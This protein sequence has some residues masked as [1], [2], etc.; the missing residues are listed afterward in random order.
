MKFNAALKLIQNSPTA[1]LGLAAMVLGQMV[2]TAVMSMT[3]VHLNH[4]GAS[5]GVIGTI[6][7]G[8]I[9][10]MYIASPLVGWGTDRFGRRPVI[11]VGTLT[12]LGSFLIAGMAPEGAHYQL[13]IGLA[14]LGLGW[15]CTLIAGSTLLT[16]SVALD[17]K[18]GVQGA[19]DLTMGMGGATAGLLSGVVVG[20]SSY[21]ML[22]IIATFMIVPLLVATLRPM[23]L[24]PAM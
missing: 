5:L 11:V 16:E 9:T 13:G 18:P 6:I 19:A 21:A 23:R 4:Q 24:Q 10:G 3:P 12:L 22:T 20:Y 2:M 1:T 14:M 7:S 17:A 8:H 15:S